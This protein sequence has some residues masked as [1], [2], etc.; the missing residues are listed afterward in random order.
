MKRSLLFSLGLTFLLG[1]CQAQIQPFQ[2]APRTAPVRQQTVAGRQAGLQLP[3][4]AALQ[5]ELQAPDLE[6]EPRNQEYN[7]AWVE[8]VFNPEH[9]VSPYYVHGH[10]DY[11]DHLSNGQST[12]ESIL[13]HDGQAQAAQWVQRW[14]SVLSAAAVWPDHHSTTYNGRFTALEHGQVSIN[15]G[16]FLFRD[17]SSKAQ[18]YYDRALDAWIPGVAADDPRQEEAWAWLGRSSHFI[19][20]MTVPFHTKALVRPAQPL[21]HHN[22][23][24]T[25]EERF[26]EYMPENNYNPFDVWQHGPYPEHEPWGFYYPASTS[27][28]ELIMLL[29]D[30]SEPFYKLVNER[31]NSKSGNWEKTRAVMVPL[32]GKATAGFIVH[33]LQE[34]GALPR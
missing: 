6:A 29:A 28:S 8:Q 34:V 13:T 30:Q 31:Q 10:S 33:F 24:I 1:A 19:Q 27:T 18:E 3:L 14:R 25:C 23:E 26:D 16:W 20:D 17:A 9:K 5:T 4:S 7:E 2:Q 11:Y 32:G 15:N 22:Y 21:F 12:V